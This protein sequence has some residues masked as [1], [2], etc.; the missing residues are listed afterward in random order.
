MAALLAYSPFSYSSDIV[1]GQSLNAASDG[2]NWVMTNVLP[3]QM[4][5]EVTNIFYR[6]TTIK[7]PLSD[8]VVYV[9]NEDAQNEGQYIFRSADD[10]S[11]LP[12]NTIVKSIPLQN[13]LGSRFGDGSIE[14]TG[15]GSVEDATVLYSYR[16]DPCFNPQSSPDC[17]GFMPPIPEI[18]DVADPLSED[19]IQNEIDRK[20][21]MADEE[22]EQEDR[23][24]VEEGGENGP[25]TESLEEMLGIAME[26]ALAASDNAAAAALSAMNA[27]PMTYTAPLPTTTYEE[28]VTLK[29]NGTL[30]RSLVRSSRGR[31]MSYA[32]DKLH[33]ELVQSQFK[34]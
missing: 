30:V 22:E 26:S 14:V 1:F 33:N 6:Y 24:R 31:R 20:A 4:G 21:V 29:D 32:Q 9:Q 23:E 7:D 13:I 19:Y 34:R 11:G 10:W 17:E 3:Q 15:E 18:P 27:L 2:Y 28:T 25:E 5:L 16:F 8:M 12:P